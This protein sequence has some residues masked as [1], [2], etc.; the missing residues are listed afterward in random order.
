MSP[1]LATTKH[2]VKDRSKTVTTSA[3]ES[4]LKNPLYFL[5]QLFSLILVF[6]YE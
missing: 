6:A 1:C 5:K 2:F 4:L 3:R